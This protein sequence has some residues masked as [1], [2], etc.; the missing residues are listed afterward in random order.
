MV[1]NMRMKRIIGILFCMILCTSE[2]NFYAKAETKTIY[3]DE[4][5]KKLFALGII[6]DKDINLD[7]DEI[8]TRADFACMIARLMGYEERNIKPEE[9]IYPDVSA[10][11]WAA[12]NIE[13]VTD[14][15]IFT[16]YGDGKFYPEEAVE[17]NQ[18]LKS[19]L[20]MAG[21]ET[22]AEYKGGYP[23]G[24][25]T[26]A[27]ELG[28]TKSISPS[29]KM[30]RSDVFALFNNSLEIP[31]YDAEFSGLVMKYNKSENETLLSHWKNIYLESGIVEAND[32]STLTSGSVGVLENGYIRIDGIRYSVG[33]TDVRG[34]LGI[35]SEI[36]YLDD[37]GEFII[38]YITPVQNR[39]VIV[40]VNA[41]DIVRDNKQ[42][43]IISYETEGGKVKNIRILPDVRVLYNGIAKP[44][45]PDDIFYPEYGEI[46]FID[47]NSDGKY[48]VIKI[49]EVTDVLVVN[50][51]GE[52]ND[53]YIINDKRDKSITYSI[54][55]D[56]DD[57]FGEI[58]RNGIFSEMRSIT[59]DD[60][61]LIG[62]NSDYGYDY[63]M[64]SS[65]IITGKISSATKDE[66]VIDG[67][68]Y[69]ISKSFYELSNTGVSIKPEPGVSGSFYIDCF[70]YLQY[71]ASL[72]I[73]SELK[74]AV[75]LKI[76]EDPENE[77]GYLRLFTEDDEIVKYQLEDKVKISSFESIS[78]VKRDYDD[79]IKILKNTNLQD[80][81]RS[82]M[83][84]DYEM[85]LIQF[86][87][88]S[89]QKINKINAV[90]KNLGNNFNENV[91]LSYNA[92]VENKSGAF[93]WYTFTIK[94]VGYMSL[95]QKFYADKNTL[96]FDV[97]ENER[98]LVVSKCEVPGA[99]G[100]G[101]SKMYLYNVG[102]DKTARVIVRYFDKNAQGKM[103]I[104][105]NSQE[106]VVTSVYDAINED[107]EAVKIIKGY[108]AGKIKE[109]PYNRNDY[110]S[111]MTDVLDKVKPGDI[112]NYTL[113]TANN[114]LGVHITVDANNHGLYLNSYDILNYRIKYDHAENTRNIYGRVI[115][116]AGD[117]L[118][119]EVQ[120]ENDLNVWDTLCINISKYNGPLY[121]VTAVNGKVN[122]DETKTL[123]DLRPG[124]SFF[125]RAG[126]RS[127]SAIYRMNYK[128]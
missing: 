55:K 5:T 109:I 103:L 64:A 105:S 122:I 127:P 20:T 17:Y 4:V 119:Y 48:E 54:K 70:G 75:I 14:M 31:Y 80:V 107:D 97:Y 29:K 121:D 74:Y 83:G 92:L 40:V 42:Q 9:D 96:F 90:S 84:D 69:E 63:I 16:G 89:G 106:L 51:V 39:N 95:G 77:T 32:T 73:D 91:P 120:S 58:V 88:S 11:Y 116:C 118:V 43:D 115:K 24:Y 8:V 33:N 68:K 22:A 3:N 50:S 101:A 53:R 111:F 76:I 79:V 99:A 47:N 104:D 61:I 117:V 62:R 110:N 81:G 113:D 123:K 34:M 71:I 112:I 28:V 67:N 1:I 102:E 7:N 86:G 93:V 21:Y 41:R 66:V 78:S 52:E 25:I 128:D 100:N 45:Y 125:M 18:I 60:T 57:V 108:T 23:N 59:T 46:T 98:Q 30:T 37:D 82:S 6:S 27:A 85:Q 38:R 19:V 35:N 87:L 36:Y 12:E 72:K 56:N 49:F 126:Y 2:M 13:Y 26:L 44:D 65:D 94:D 124:D 15:K 114:F 10:D